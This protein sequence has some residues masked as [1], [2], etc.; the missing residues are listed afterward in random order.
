MKKIRPISL[1]EEY[2]RISNQDLLELL[3]RKFPKNKEINCYQS[4]EKDFKLSHKELMHS[5]LDFKLKNIF[6]Y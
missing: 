6:K 3:E 5:K 1:S 4:K 2:Q